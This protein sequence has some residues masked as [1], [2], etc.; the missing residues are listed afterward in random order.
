MT[1]A[2]VI[3]AAV[4]LVGLILKLTHRPDP[5]SEDTLN[6][7]KPLSSQP[8]ALSSEEECCGLHAVC[9]KKAAAVA[10][11]DYYDDE[12]LD[13]YAGRDPE[14]FS[15]DEVEEFRQVLYTLIPAD[16][17]PWGA[18]LTR[19]GIQLPTALRD[20]WIMLCEEK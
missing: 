19:R 2:L 11:H 10:G 12:E 8:S 9:E 4:I 16:V 7:D 1:G 20:E 18:S 6:S 14:S 5:Q 13:R 15:D 17:F 3:L